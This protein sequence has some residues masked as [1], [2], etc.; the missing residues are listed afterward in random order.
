M[1]DQTDRL[2][3][4]VH[5]VE[6]DGPSR[7]YF[8]ALTNLMFFFLSFVFGNPLENLNG[9]VMI[10]TS[11]ANLLTDYF[12]L[13]GVG[14][15]FLNVS[16]VMSLGLL[17]IRVSKTKIS[18]PVYAAL[19]M[20]TGFAFFG[21][22]PLNSLPIALGVFLSA[23]YSQVA[24]RVYIGPALFG[25]AMGP[26][27]SELAF[28]QGLPIPLGLL[29]G[30]LAGIAAGFILPPLAKRFLSFHQ[31]F[32]LYNIG[33]TSGIITMV[34]MG[35]FELFGFEVHISA[36]TAS[37][38]TQ[39]MALTF[40]LFFAITL[41]IGLHVC[42][43][44]LKGYIKLTKLVGQNGEDFIAETSFGLVLVNMAILGFVT[45]LYV[46]ILGGEL[47]GPA[48]GSILTV[49]GFAAAGKHLKNVLPLMAGVLLAKL[50][51]ADPINITASVIIAIFATNLAP[52]AGRYGFIAGAAAGFI[53][54]TITIDIA[55]LH[56]GMNLYNN[57]FAGGFVA[58]F[59]VVILDYL[60]RRY[61]AKV[62]V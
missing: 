16:L 24:F 60:E 51:N 11:P 56:G 27:V 42:R 58:A 23:R 54:L 25:T 29:L 28:G 14:G 33:F 21:T 40:S 35:I 38:Y 43:W 62:K 3:S 57:G 47:N 46:L 22:N 32:C 17:V 20:M 44:N 34:F 4:N 30:F 5:S 18:G 50:L 10:L 37:G 12:V 45:M 53:H 9:L 13:G 1:I 59:M 19:F 41:I 36:L 8:A 48:I 15:A 49:V 2:T 6:A 7:F 31:G 26:M 52:I 55:Y 61:K 39:S